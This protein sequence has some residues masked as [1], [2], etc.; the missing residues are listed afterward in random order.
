MRRCKLVF[1]EQVLGGKGGG[2]GVRVGKRKPFSPHPLPMRAT[3]CESSQTYSSIW[4]GYKISHFVLT[5]LVRVLSLTVDSRFEGF[6]VTT[7]LNFGRR[8]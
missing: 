3:I 1:C 7:L 8:P 4:Q 6:V 2:A 5:R